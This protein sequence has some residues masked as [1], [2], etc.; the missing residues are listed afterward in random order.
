M[1]AWTD[2]RRW[3]GVAAGLL[4]VFAAKAAL[5]DIPVDSPPKPP[6]QRVVPT[7]ENGRLA[8]LV[9]RFDGSQEHSRIVIPRQFLQAAVPGGYFP[10]AAQ[11]AVPGAS[12][13]QRRSIVAGT[14]LSGVIA[15]GFLGV[16]FA[17]RRKVSLAMAASIGVLATLVVMVGFAA[18][19]MG[20]PPKD[21]APNPV[22]AGAPQIVVEPAGWTR[23][24]VRQTPQIMVETTN[25]G[26][27]VI[28]VI[29][30]DAP[31]DVK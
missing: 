13:W 17:R 2:Q 31:Q 3:L 22:D 30:R 6:S 8:P 21:Y 28:L 25:R 29:G 24:L 10:P 23:P 5:A 15:F 27:Q 4:F 1:N 16:V 19:N 12:H 26:D 18:A 11:P 14:A 20:L 9:I 7:P